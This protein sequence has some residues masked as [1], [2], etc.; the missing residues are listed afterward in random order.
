M[1]EKLY[2][3]TP[4]YNPRNFRRRIQLYKEFEKYL[5]CEEDAVLVTVEVAF[6][7]RPYECTDPNNPFHLR[8]RSDQELWHKEKCINLG[9][10]HLLKIVPDAKKIAWIDADVRFLNPHWVKETLKQL[11]HFDVVQ[12]FSYTMGL[13]PDYVNLGG[14]GA[15]VFFNYCHKIFPTPEEKKPAY[16]DNIAQGHP[17]LAWAA[18]TE[19]LNKLGGLMDYCVFGSADSH[20]CNALMGDVRSYFNPM[21]PSAG[22]TRA[23]LKWQ[24]KADLIKKNIGYVDGICVHYWHGKMNLRG[25]EEKWEIICRHQ[26]DPYEDVYPGVNGLY[27]WAGNK[28]QL[29]QDLRHSAMQRNEDSIDW[30]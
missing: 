17:G 25:Y 6:G 12:M 24:E 15:S 9:I 21:P 23:F 16:G 28:K 5:S 7:D 26:Y 29:E 3:V 30:R 13:R 1:S 10:Q 14:I 8:L 11:E 20:M 18:T 4:V 2:V 22:L 19:A 27:Q